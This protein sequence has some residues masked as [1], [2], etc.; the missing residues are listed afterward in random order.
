LIDDDETD[1]P[2]ELLSRAVGARE[3]RDPLPAWLVPSWRERA[4]ALGWSALDL[5]TIEAFASRTGRP[6]WGVTV[7]RERIAIHHF[8]GT[9]DFEPSPD[10]APPLVEHGPE[11]PACAHHGEALWLAWLACAD[12]R[13]ASPPQCRECARFFYPARP[14][15]ARAFFPPHSPIPPERI[16]P[17]APAAPPVVA[18]PAPTRPPRPEYRQGRLF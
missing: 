6:T 2:P 3:A 5:D 15:T 14:V 9:W 7:T 13:P 11:R 10:E 4:E 17:P 16:T 12:R 18:P 8:A 1:V